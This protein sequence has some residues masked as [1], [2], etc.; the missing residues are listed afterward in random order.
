MNGKPLYFWTLNE[1]KKLK[2][3]IDTIISTDDKKIILAAKKM[4]F[5]VPFQR[6]KHLSTNKSKIIDTIKY[7]LEYYKKKIFSIKMLFYYKLHLHLE[8]KKI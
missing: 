3:K 7:V 6:P 1:L 5:N 8:Q 2:N 4:K